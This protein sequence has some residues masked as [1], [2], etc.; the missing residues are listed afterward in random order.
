VVFAGDLRDAGEA[1][2]PRDL[3]EEGV[4]VG[5]VALDLE[6]LSFSEAAARDQ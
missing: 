3:P 6:A 1:A 2:A 4:G 5:D